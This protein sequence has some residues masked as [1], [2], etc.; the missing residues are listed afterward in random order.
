[1]HVRRIIIWAVAAVP[2]VAATGYADMRSVCSPGADVQA[3]RSCDQPDPLCPAHLTSF[4]RVGMPYGGPCSAGYPAAAR[5]DVARTDR[6][7]PL[8]IFR[9]EQDSLSFCLY[10]LLGLGLLKSAPCAKRLS[11]GVVPGWY[12]DGGPFQVGHSLAVSPDCL[13]RAT[14]CFVQPDLQAEDPLPQCR[15][16]T[17]STTSRE[18]Q[19]S[20]NVLASR[21]PPFASC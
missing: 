4:G 21:G 8:H 15:S 14:V 3:A 2:V 9:H 16:H 17:L 18:S 7:Q 5:P 6:A 11:L 20:P 13:C 1:M 19:F 10:A 12:H